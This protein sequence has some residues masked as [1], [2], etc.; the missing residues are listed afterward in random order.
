MKILRRGSRDPEV[1]L[2]QRLLNVTYLPTRGFNGISEDGI[3]GQ[4]TE[5]LLRRFQTENRTR[6]GTVD[7]IAGPQTWS[8][9]GLQSEIDYRLPRTGQNTG[10]TCWAVSGG[11]ASGRM[12]SIAAAGVETDSTPGPNSFGGLY[13]DTPNME[14]YARGLG[15]RLLPVLPATQDEIVGHLRRGPVI[16]NG[17]WPGSGQ[18]VVVISGYFET[19]QPN[20]RMIKVNDP[21]PMG[22]GSIH[23][24]EYPS[25]IVSDGPLTP[26]HVIV[27]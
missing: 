6:L 22:Q 15:M 8:A 21:L 16:V 3:F 5:T 1:V 25:L 10:M 13:T 17:R 24:T 27:R 19:R 12:A 14:A 2:L 26:R 11:L 4:E 7:G 23:V 20:A 9:L 18:H